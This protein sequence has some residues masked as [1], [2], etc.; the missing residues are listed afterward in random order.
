[1]LPRINTSF[2]L[3][4][5]DDDWWKT[6]FEP[7]TTVDE[8][9]A[10]EVEETDEVEELDSV[11]RLHNQLADAD[12]PQGNTGTSNPADREATPSASDNGT[13]GRRRTRLAVR[14]VPF[15]YPSTY[16]DSHLSLKKIQH[17]SSKKRRTWSSDT[18]DP[19]NEGLSLSPTPR[20]VRRKEQLS[21]T[22]SHSRAGQMKAPLNLTDL[23][24]HTS[25]PSG[26]SSASMSPD[27]T[28]NVG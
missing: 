19:L 3:F 27:F 2:L 16:L 10:E 8:E 5:S 25:P 23:A 26:E 22:S 14:K 1:M 28:I 21:P 18:E 17:A 13:L 7:P 9:V 15:S 12:T 11:N 4:Q 24:Y 20:R 6:N